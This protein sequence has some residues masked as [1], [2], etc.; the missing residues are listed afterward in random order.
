[1]AIQQYTCESPFLLECGETLQ[2]LEI[3]YH[4]YGTMN[5]AGTNVVW[6]CHALTANSDAADWWKGLVGEGCL[7][8]PADYFIV[9]ANIIG[10]CY[11][12]TGPL[13]MNSAIH[14]P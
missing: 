9:C 11:V 1:M 4:T 10:S 6:V 12:L 2:G 13:S 8:N 14:K 3:A 5:T 7:I